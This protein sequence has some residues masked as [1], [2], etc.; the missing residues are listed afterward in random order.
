MV[1]EDFKFDIPYNKSDKDFCLSCGIIFTI[2]TI[3]GL[4]GI[5]LLGYNGYNIQYI[6]KSQYTYLPANITTINQ[7][8]YSCTYF[9]K[10]GD[11]CVTAPD[12]TPSCNQ[13]LNEFE[14]GLCDNGYFCCYSSGKGSCKKSTQHQSR[15]INNG[16]CYNPIIEYNVTLSNGIY[17]KIE[18]QRK[19]CYEPN[20]Y[21]CMINELDGF[22]VGQ[23]I[24]IYYKE[25]NNILNDAPNCKY[26]DEYIAGLVLV[27]FTTII[28]IYMSASCYINVCIISKSIN[29]SK[30][31]QP[32]KMR[33]KNGPLTMYRTIRIAPTIVEMKNKNTSTIL[34][35]TN[36]IKPVN[37]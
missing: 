6:C 37:Y 35:M 8:P 15:N 19:K 28:L 26:P 12:N 25:S 17:S 24:M 33:R 34:E 36:Q 27:G 21:E 20:A 16:I 14:T 3:T 31:I 23:Q 13:L 4:I 2:L 1:L 32:M 30:K 18:Q 9:T 10:V 22:Y 7:N 11:N 29:K 5:G